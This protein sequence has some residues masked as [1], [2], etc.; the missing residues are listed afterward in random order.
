MAKFTNTLYTVDNL[1]MLSGMNI[2][3]QQGKMALS[4]HLRCFL[5]AA[6]DVVFFDRCICVH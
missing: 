5:H 3:I 1:F 6:V 4:L 2:G